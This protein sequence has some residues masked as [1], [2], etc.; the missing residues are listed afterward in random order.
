MAFWATTA[1]LKKL[2]NKSW[3]VTVIFTATGSDGKNYKMLHIDRRTMTMWLAKGVCLS[4][5]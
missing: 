3:A 4:V 5:C 2:K 1:Q